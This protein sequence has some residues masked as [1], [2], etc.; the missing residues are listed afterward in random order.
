MFA[1]ARSSTRAL[2]RGL[3]APRRVHS[4]VRAAAKD[5]TKESDKDPLYAPKEEFVLKRGQ[6][7][8]DVGGKGRQIMV[9]SAA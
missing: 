1:L 3:R 4:S 7:S 2:S 5:W 9:R 6:R 8:A